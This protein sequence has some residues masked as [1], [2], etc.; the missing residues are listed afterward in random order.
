MKVNDI[1]KS[2]WGYDQTN[3]QFYQVI[4]ATPKTAT[5][6]EIA[7]EQVS[8]DNGWTGKATPVLNHFIDSPIRKK[9]HAYSNEEFLKLSSYEY[10]RP[11]NG[12]P[13]NYSTYA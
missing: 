7:V 3:I 5:V 13:V 4:K 11:W 8:K 9:I 6:R 10:A 12:T 1:L 2:R